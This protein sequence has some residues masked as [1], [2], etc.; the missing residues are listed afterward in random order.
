MSSRLGARR[1][2]GG[3]QGVWASEVDDP[4]LTAVTLWGVPPHTP[5]PTGACYPLYPLDNCCHALAATNAQGH[6]AGGQVAALELIEEGAEQH[7]A[8]GAERVAKS[9][10]A[11]VHVDPVV[12]D[13]ELAH[14][15]D[16]HHR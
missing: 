10:G 6:E 12:I 1:G 7:G 16:G 8:G 4:R 3:P 13:A 2:S 5:L 9:N 11:T 15:V 14:G